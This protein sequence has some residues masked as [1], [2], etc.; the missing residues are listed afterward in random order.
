MIVSDLSVL[1][2]CSACSGTL[3][4]VHVSDVSAEAVCRSCG[5]RHLVFTAESGNFDFHSKRCRWVEADPSD[6][7]YFDVV[8]VESGEIVRRFHGWNQ[9]SATLWD[10]AQVG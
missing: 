8:E 7:S 4:L 1:T 9:A 5:G 2:S 6:L 10:V 3:D